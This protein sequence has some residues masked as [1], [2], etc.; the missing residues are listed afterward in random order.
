M[1]QVG[2]RHF[3]DFL[4]KL[5]AQRGSVE[6]EASARVR[7]AVATKPGDFRKRRAAYC[8]SSGKS[9]SQLGMWD[10][11]AG[12]R[13]VSLG[14]QE[15]RDRECNRAHERPTKGRASSETLPPDP[16]GNPAVKMVRLRCRRSA[17]LDRA[18]STAIGRNAGHLI[19]ERLVRPRRIHAARELS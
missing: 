7:T 9:R 11:R 2:I 6:I 14:L 12:R 4:T 3:S 16:Q 13:E 19:S 18:W 10:R 17:G 8:R 15:A 1:R 5:G